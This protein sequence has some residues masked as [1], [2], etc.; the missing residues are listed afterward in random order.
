M[1]KYIKILSVAVFGL[2][3]TNCAGNYKIKSEKGKVVNTVPKWYMADFLKLKLV[4]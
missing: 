3:L 1:N 2:L 4:M